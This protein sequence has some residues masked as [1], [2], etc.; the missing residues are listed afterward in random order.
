LCYVLPA[1]LLKI[2]PYEYLTGGKKMLPVPED[3]R[4]IFPYRG[5]RTVY[6][7]ASGR[8]CEDND[9]PAPVDR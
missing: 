9:H 8:R 7:A 2:Q 3:T 1:R 4:S 6:D 5:R